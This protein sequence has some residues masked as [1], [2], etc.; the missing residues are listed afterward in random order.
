MHCFFPTVQG[1]WYQS[2]SLEQQAMMSF[3]GRT[4]EIRTK[5]RTVVPFERRDSLFIWNNNDYDETSEQCN[6]ANGDPFSLRHKRSGHN[7]VEHIYKQKHH[8]IG[9]KLSE[10]DLT[11]YE[12]CQLNKSKKLSL[13]NDSGKTASE[14][15]KIVNTNILGPIKPEAVNG[16]RYAIG[17]VDNFS[18]YQKLDFLKSQFEAIR[19][20]PC[21]RK[22][23]NSFFADIGQPGTLVRDG[24][25][26]YVSNDIKKIM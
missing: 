14:A 13:P 16:H 26:E 11:N 17:F 12:T 9:L 24:A 25:G 10:H 3:F 19:K 20:I 4:L 18:R 23:Q 6:L 1:T 5:K 22:I 2:Q 21:M 15:L 7:N 8:V